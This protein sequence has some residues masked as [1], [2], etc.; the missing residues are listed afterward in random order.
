MVV[1]DA[2]GRTVRTVWSGPAPSADIPL[3]T[4]GLAAGVYTVRARSADGTVSVRVVV[5]R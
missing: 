5:A 2:L 4:R 3:D 1:L